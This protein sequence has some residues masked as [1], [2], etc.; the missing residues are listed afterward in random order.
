M[1]ISTQ[2]NTQ[3]IYNAWS[4]II[5]HEEVLTLNVFLFLITLHTRITDR[6][7]TAA[8]TISATKRQIKNV[9]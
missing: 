2:L 6:I 1:A 7:E 8:E 4:D 5:R 9:C 3:C